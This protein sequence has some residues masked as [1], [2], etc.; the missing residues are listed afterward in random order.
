MNYSNDKIDFVITWVDGNDPVWR[1]EKEQYSPHRE[2]NAAS[3]NRFRDWDLLRYWFRG[4]EKY[5]P[6][7]NHIYFVTCGHKPEWLNLDHPKLT[8]VS[9]RDYI[10]QEYLPTFNSNVIILNT[11]RI[12][13][14][15]EHFVHFND[16]MFLTGE[17]SPED[18]FRG[19]VPCGA[20]LLSVV[21]AWRQNDVFP[22]TMLNNAALINEHFQK[23]EVLKKHWNK[24]FSPKYS[25]KELLRNALCLPLTYFTCFHS[26]HLPIS[27][28]KSSFNEVWEAEKQVLQNTCTHRF[29]S[30]EDIADWVMKDWQVCQGKV[31]P[32][33]S[34][35]GLHFE[36]GQD[37][38]M[39]CD[40]IRMQKYKTI[41]INDSSTDIDF[42]ATKEALIQSFQHVL[43]EKSAFEL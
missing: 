6:W 23:K 24:F 15:E 26:R 41:C 40:A 16:D 12:K 31:A 30:V 7:V 5:A 33:S 17:M 39:V 22:H 35:W 11:H 29:R 34:K 27:Y 10:P 9:H 36:L 28:L 1:A 3:E 4:V 2:D 43:P 32:R 37:N 38:K 20:A 25:A 13:G 14:L 8:L 18:F 19:G 21:A 42:D